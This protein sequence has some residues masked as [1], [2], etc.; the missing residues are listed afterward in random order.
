ML[1]LCSI[2][3]LSATALHNPSRCVD[4]HQGHLCSRVPGGCVCACVW[5]CLCLEYSFVFDKNVDEKWRD[6]SYCCW[7]CW[8]HCISTTV[9]QHS[10]HSFSCYSTAI[11]HALHY[12]VCDTWAWP[13]SRGN[14]IFFGRSVLI[15]PKRLKTRTSNLAGVFPGIVPTW[16]PTKAS[17]MWAL[18]WCHGHV[19]S[20]F[21][22]R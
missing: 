16:P 10:K 19:T 14:V 6:S 3:V 1:I 12:T 8:V 5:V 21:F 13:G 4:W 17:D 2:L 22:G 15:A 18:P 20:E 11:L 7:C 9:C